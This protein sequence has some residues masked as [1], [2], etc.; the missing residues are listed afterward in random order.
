[1]KLY[2]ILKSYNQALMC[3]L[4][5]STFDEAKIKEIIK[6][7]EPQDGIFDGMLT[8]LDP[9]VID[10]L[11]QPISRQECAHLLA[12][13]LNTIFHA[14]KSLLLGRQ[15]SDQDMSYAEIRSAQKNLVTQNPF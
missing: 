14:A 3:L 9:K 4:Q 15:M 12:T 10:A 5:S 11:Q 1:M 13:G 2:L 8:P 7:L 6:T